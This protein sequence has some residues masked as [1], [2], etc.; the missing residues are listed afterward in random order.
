VRTGIAVD[1][2]VVALAAGIAALVAAGVLVW[3]VGHGSGGHGASSYPPGLAP[4]AASVAP[5]GS[6]GA[7]A[8]G[9]ASGVA[10]PG[11]TQGTDPAA[12][13]AAGFLTELGAIDPALVTDPDRALAAGR[14]TCQDL[15]AHRSD[16]AVRRAVVERFRT[17][18]AAM[19]EGEAA[20]IVDAARNHLCP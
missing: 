20:L 12:Q 15:A 19:D 5:A 14:A 17:S 6:P 8:P 13:A 18:T 3:V 2:R 4:S 16:D 9:R 1:R 10:R 11:A 7:G